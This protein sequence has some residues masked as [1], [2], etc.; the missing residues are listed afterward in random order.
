[1]LAHTVDDNLVTK[2]LCIAIEQFSSCSR[3]VI[4]A[5]LHILRHNS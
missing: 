1:M 5:D 2:K 4:E 3:E